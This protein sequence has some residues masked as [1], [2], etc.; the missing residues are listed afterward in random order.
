MYF[1]QAFLL[2]SFNEFDLLIVSISKDVLRYGGEDT[3]LRI[4]PMN[5]CFEEPNYVVSYNKVAKY[6]S[7]DSQNA[8][9]DDLIEAVNSAKVAGER[10]GN[11]PV[12][13]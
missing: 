7:P 4:V 5:H 11:C 2:N 9:K 12:D 10:Y 13:G 3:A 8:S 1:L 6:A